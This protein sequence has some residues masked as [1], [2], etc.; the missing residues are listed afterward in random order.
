MRPVL[1]F[2][3][4][5]ST[6]FAMQV[7]LLYVSSAVGPQTTTVTGS[8]LQ[9]AQAH[10]KANDITGVL[11]QGEGLFLQVLEGE[12]SKV[13]RLYAR[14]LADQRHKDVELLV[15]EEISTRRFGAWSMAHVELSNLD[16]M[17]RMKHPEFDPY[18][19]AGALVMRQVDE[20]IASSQ[21]IRVLPN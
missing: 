3:I 9:S 18:S 21:L 14:I 10:N 8:I 13:N 12:R 6:G 7:R 19:A 4:D 17:V 5:A 16:P 11:C 1:L 15:F 2:R 20:M